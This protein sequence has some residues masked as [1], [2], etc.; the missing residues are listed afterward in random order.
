MLSKNL[1]LIIRQYFHNK[2]YTIINISGL[3]IALATTL[4]I[5]SFIIKEVQ[6]DHF[7]K[8]SSEIYRVILKPSPSEPYEA[9]LCEPLAPA[10]QARVPGIK[11]YTRIWANHLKVKTEQNTEFGGP[12]L[13]LHSDQALFSMFTFPFTAGEVT[14]K[15]EKGWVVISQDA[16][17]RYFGNTN[18]VG[19]TISMKNENIFWLKT[20]CDYQ[21]AAVMQDIPEWSTI[22]ADF[23]F[24]YR[25]VAGFSDWNSNFVLYTFLQLDKNTSREKIE[26]EIANLYSETDEG[27]EVKPHLQ[28]LSKIYFNKDNVH[29][30]RY[31]PYHPQGSLLFTQMLCGIALLI[32][33]LASCNYIMIRVAQGQRNLKTFAIQRCFGSGSN[34]VK[35]QALQET[36]LIFLI[37]GSIA[38]PLTIWLFPVFR[39]IISPIHPYAFPLNLQSVGLFSLFIL[40]F[41]LTIGYTLGRHFTGRL[42]RDGIRGTLQTKNTTFDLKKV[43][44]TLQITIFCILFASTV[45]IGKQMNY[46]EHKD[47][48]FNNQNTLSLYGCGETLKSKLL[49]HPDILAASTGWGLPEYN[50]LFFTKNYVFENDRNT[51]IEASMICGDT[52]YLDTYQIQLTAGRNYD[53]NSSPQRE[54]IVPILVNQEFVR[55]A[56]LQNPIGTVFHD[57]EDE[58]RECYFEIIGIVKDFNIY[59]LYKSIPPLMLAYS[60]GPSTGCC[61]TENIT[62][63]YRE[64][65]K[66]EVMDFL[67][68]SGISPHSE[69]QYD[70]LYGKEN[71]FIRLIHIFTLIAICMGGS[72]LFAFS[73]FL[74]ENRRKEIALR[75][76]N[77]ALEWDIHKQFY[78]EFTRTTFY[79]CITG[80]PLAYYFINFWLKTFAYKTPLEWWIF[81]ATFAVCLLFVILVIT[82]QT[83]K[84]VAMNPVE[85]LHEK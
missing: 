18:P 64:N 8:N 1:Q 66:A 77:G 13:C 20:P 3:A 41:I 2:V 7:H 74:S 70:T 26:A 35:I 84:A 15:T 45:I 63:R 11:S 57:P 60:T 31:R 53:K 27:A 24:D 72:G 16:A 54:G 48:G 10:I 58:D 62:I 30:S 42:N 65:K 49:G 80:L 33:F 51:Q 34:S 19:R 5:Y 25:Q 67:Q 23:I 73:V 6:T 32:L 78:R 21:V 47:L 61:N 22:Q 82:W 55:Q 40:L 59:A 38:I 81:P 69:Y 46:L 83:R 14:P 52:D 44:A 76:I 71:A 28:P 43:L 29:Y 36:T 4:L 9:T 37:S 12:E 39:Q 75:K 56:H 68:E 85:C 17:L 50:N 79:A